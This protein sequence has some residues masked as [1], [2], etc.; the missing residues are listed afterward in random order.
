MIPG[1]WGYSLIRRETLDGCGAKVEVFGLEML[2]YSERY[3]ETYRRR[4]SQ[5]DGW[6]E[7]A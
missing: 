7:E 5:E 3:F 4:M 6:I 1:T 2:L